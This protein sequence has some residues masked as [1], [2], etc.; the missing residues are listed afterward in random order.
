MNPMPI[1]RSVLIWLYMYPPM[2]NFSPSKTMASKCL[3]S[4]VCLTLA[5]CVMSSIAFILR[6][7]MTD[8]KDTL[9]ATFPTIACSGLV[10]VHVVAIH[11]RQNICNLF[12]KL[13]KIYQTSEWSMENL[14]IFIFCTP[15]LPVYN[16][17]N[18]FQPI[19]PLTKN[20]I[21]FWL[22]RAIKVIWFGN[23]TSNTSWV[24][25]QSI[26]WRWQL[27]LFGFVGWWMVNL[28]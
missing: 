11:S 13:S 23:S 22:R 21:D 16:H 10:Y 8:L 28:T 15:C 5:G 24:D 20:P 12:K 27:H 14:R 19:Q 6:F 4:A 7:I 17:M 18:F 25:L 2:E 26:R 9:Y 3:T 1:N